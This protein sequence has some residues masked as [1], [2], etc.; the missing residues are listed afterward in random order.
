MPPK[1]LRTLVQKGDPTIERSLTLR[2]VGDWGHAN[3]HKLMTFITQEFTER[4]GPLSRT[5]IWS[6]AGGGVEI[7]DMIASGVADIAI[8]TPVKLLANARTGKGFWESRG[9]VPTMRALATIPQNDRMILGL[10]PSLGCKTFADLREKKPRI[11]LIMSPKEESL[12][13]TP[14]I[15]TWMPMVSL[16]RPSNPGVGR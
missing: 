7:T 4:C 16:W 3:F 1:T 11:K 12:I 9:P 2:C 13:A 8:N 15:V 14:L 6:V 10:D 5:L